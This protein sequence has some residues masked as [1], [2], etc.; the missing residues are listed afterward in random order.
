[1]RKF[2]KKF[3]AAAAFAI[4][5]LMIFTSS[6]FAA[7]GTMTSQITPSSG[8]GEGDVFE[9]TLTFKGKG[10]A[11]G[12]LN[13]SLSYDESAL[14]YMSG[15]GAAVELSGGTGGIT[16]VGG[17]GIYNLSYVLRFTALKAGTTQLKISDCEIIGYTSGADIGII[18]T[19]VN[20]NISPKTSGGDSESGV[21]T[22]DG[23][24]PVDIS[25]ETYY[26]IKDFSG[27]TTPEGYSASTVSYNGQD[28]TGAYSE[29]TGLTL[30]CVMDQKGAYGLY[31]YKDGALYPYVVFNVNRSYMIIE[32]ELGPEGY[33][34]CE[35]T[36]DGVTVS[37]WDKADGSFPVVYAVD[38][39]GAEGYFHVDAENKTMIPVTEPLNTVEADKPSQEDVK[40]AVQNDIWQTHGVMIAVV[41]GSLAVL[42][43]IAAITAASVVSKK[44][45]ALL[46]AKEYEKT[47][48]EPV[49][50]EIV[51]EEAEEQT[52]DK[53]DE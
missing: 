49:K 7:T 34:A 21:D 3:T 36:I 48:E 38:N 42:T 45:Q 28:I 51:K 37:A 26:I 50:E 41:L 11:I 16:D 8:V 27:C 30:L 23:V 1:M 33:T 15:G 17:E 12:A 46:A 52:E 31:V 25:G 22:D 47:A 32:K 39:E 35:I 6:A 24:I 10:E 2:L 40:P 53:E 19:A 20:I 18:N 4:V 13:A 9:I 43:V 14:K 29:Q 5:A 44:K